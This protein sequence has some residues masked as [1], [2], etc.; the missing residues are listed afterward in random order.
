[1]SRVT[2][3]CSRSS[4]AAVI[5]YI[6]EVLVA[7]EISCDSSCESSSRTVDVARPHSL[8]DRISQVQKMPKQNEWTAMVHETM[9]PKSR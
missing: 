5:Q 9:K 6:S 1:M 7:S 8:P 3:L 4:S 2:R